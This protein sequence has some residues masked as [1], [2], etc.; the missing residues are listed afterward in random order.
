MPVPWSPDSRYI[1]LNSP[2]HHPKGENVI[3]D[4][5][6]KEAYLI[7]EKLNSYGWIIKNGNDY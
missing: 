6:K 1:V 4:V 3:V 2:V 7:K 5:E